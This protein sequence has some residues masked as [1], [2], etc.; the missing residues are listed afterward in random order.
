MDSAVSSFY[1][2]ATHLFTAETAETAESMWGEE[3]RMA[4]RW[5]ASNR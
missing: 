3:E 5:M 2:S 4:R 1:R